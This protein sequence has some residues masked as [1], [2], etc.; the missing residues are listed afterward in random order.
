MVAVKRPKPAV[1]ADSAQH[2]MWA[3]EIELMRKLQHK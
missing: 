1:F 3:N 2:E